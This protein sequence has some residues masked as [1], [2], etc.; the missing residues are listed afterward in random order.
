MRSFVGNLERLGQLLAD[1]PAAGALW[2]SLGSQLLASN[3]S[4]EALACFHRAD[5]MRFDDAAFFT[6]FGIA[7]SM[8]GDYLAAV[9]SYKRSLAL[10]P[11][12]SDTYFLVAANDKTPARSYAERQLKRAA[13]LNPTDFEVQF[14]LGVAY[15]LVGQIDSSASHLRKAICLTPTDTGSYVNLSAITGQSN[16]PILMIKHAMRA[17]LLDSSSTEARQNIGVAYSKM[18]ASR[19]ALYWVSQAY[20][21]QPDRYELAHNI[22]EFYEADNKLDQAGKWQDTA[23][24][25]APSAAAV[26]T[27]RATLLLK[28]GEFAAGWSDYEYRVE[29]TPF[30]SRNP[31]PT[32]LP[33]L[34]TTDSLD[35]RRLV[36]L[37]EQGLGDSI[38]F[39]RF[40]RVM[41]QFGCHIQV[42]IQEALHNL[43][44]T[45]N[46]DGIEII[47]NASDINADY[48]CWLLSTPHQILARTG[49]IT[50]WDGS[51]IHAG[52]SRQ[53]EAPLTKES[54][55]QTVGLMWR[56]TPDPAYDSR[57]LDLNLLLA[58]LPNGYQYVCLQRELTNEEKE[59]LKRDGRTVTPQRETP[60]DF[61][62]TANVISTCSAVISIDTSVAHLAGS[63]GKPMI[64]L[65]KYNADWRWGRPSDEQS[66]WYPQAQLIRQTRQGDWHSAL[67]KVSECLRNT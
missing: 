21:L 57:S 27:Q 39:F 7:L 67:T 37:C 8:R 55:I 1:S 11:S 56:G 42:L 60:L 33:R 62:A 41:R 63:M 14:Q 18:G 17:S 36:L 9:V 65:L 48:F 46:R 52:R 59:I 4:N 40:A 23:L 34:K 12:S 30:K 2:A 24:V 29:T 53:S 58:C 51:Y 16:Q 45:G 32:N 35:G 31:L 44:N 19:E 6:N 15:A 64:L 28:R 22:A 47:H 38:Q 10:N 49:H 54:K 26:R 25:L 50:Y 61:E 43:L 20:L 13:S 3:R 66:V 5:L